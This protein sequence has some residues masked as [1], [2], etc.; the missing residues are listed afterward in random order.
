MYLLLILHWGC[1]IRLDF[2]FVLVLTFSFR[3]VIVILIILLLILFVSW[4]LNHGHHQ[5]L[6]ASNTPLCWAYRIAGHRLWL[7]E[8]AT[9]MT[10]HGSCNFLYITEESFKV[11][12]WAWP[13]RLF[14]VYIPTLILDG[15]S[16]PL[17]WWF[18]IRDFTRDLD[19][20]VLACPDR[21]WVRILHIHNFLN[22]PQLNLLR[23]S[24]LFVTVE[25]LLCS[26]L[27]ILWV[28]SWSFASVSVPWF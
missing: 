3:R 26:I 21:V 14:V 20:D 25:P 7:F 4:T 19:Y 27:Y 16:K 6:V 28:S 18:R 24:Y 13:S 2:F 15:T 17:P 12:E 5:R 9:I 1:R 23:L 10:Y 8:S 11:I 22:L